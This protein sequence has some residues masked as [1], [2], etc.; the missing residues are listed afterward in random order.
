MTWLPLYPFGERL[1]GPQCQCGHGD[2]EKNFLYLPRIKLWS[3]A[4]NQ[5]LY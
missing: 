2:E 3:S 1:G 5:S 4:H